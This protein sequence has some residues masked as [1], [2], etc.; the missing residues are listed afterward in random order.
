MGAVVGLRLKKSD[1]KLKLF[2]ENE[3]YD[4]EEKFDLFLD[5]ISNFKSF[6]SVKFIFTGKK[7]IKIDFPFSFCFKRNKFI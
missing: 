7:L 5:I 2:N 3:Y 6:T 4:D 1:E